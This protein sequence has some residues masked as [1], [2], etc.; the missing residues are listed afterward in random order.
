M[1]TSGA[2]AVV[3]PQ[4]TEPVTSKKKMNTAG[5]FMNM[6]TQ[7]ALSCHTKKNDGLPEKI[8]L[9]YWHVMHGCHH[10]TPGGVSCCSFF[11]DSL[12]FKMGFSGIL[13]FRSSLWSSV[14]S[15][16]GMAIS[17]SARGIIFNTT[18]LLAALMIARFPNYS[19]YY[20][21]CAECVSRLM[22]GWQPTES[23]PL[24]QAEV[25]L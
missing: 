19:K 21:Y 5:I 1:Q 3:C 7:S 22:W 9:H 23:Q 6:L 4:T 24:V 16:T 18:G 25:L 13:V 2:E 12:K 10:C 15:G 11:Q 8:L 14:T 17:D 20:K